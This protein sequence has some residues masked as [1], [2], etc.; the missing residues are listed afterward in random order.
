MEW[1]FGIAFRDSVIQHHLWNQRFDGSITMNP[2][3]QTDKS[4]YVK[5][6]LAREEQVTCGVFKNDPRTHR[7]VHEKYAISEM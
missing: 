6:F 5:Q 7:T 4:V 3:Y 1:I 2:Q